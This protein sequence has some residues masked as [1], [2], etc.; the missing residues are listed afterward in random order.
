VSRL[1]FQS[2]QGQH[3]ELTGAS[4][5]VLCAITAVAEAV[6]DSL[7]LRRFHVVRIKNSTAALK[8]AA[9][10]DLP[11]LAIVIE[12]EAA[13]VVSTIQTLK[14]RWP[15]IKVVAVGLPNTEES[16]MRVI[17]SGV[18]GIVLAEE[19]LDQLARACLDVLGDNIR[20][21]PQAVRPLFDRLVRLD[22]PIDKGQRS[23]PF[24]RLSGREVE[25]LNCL[26][27]G[28]SNKAIATELHIEVQTVKNHINQILRK[29]DVHSRF[30]AARLGASHLTEPT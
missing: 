18:D 5:L 11:R 17:R 2:T 20:L 1:Q 3:A 14:R 16:L 15:R 8:T 30:D 27:R 12:S 25:I 21:P 4:S 29:L 6:V 23:A 28:E 22:Q 7:G 24:V 19:P 9:S 26:E 13:V 10:A